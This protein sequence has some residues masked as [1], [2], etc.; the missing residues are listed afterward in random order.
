M[1][2]EIYIL[3]PSKLKKLAD[4]GYELDDET[5]PGFALRTYDPKNVIFVDIMG[6]C[7]GIPGMVCWNEKERNDEIREYIESE[8]KEGIFYKKV[9]GI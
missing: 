7:T 5:M 9:K 3:E 6:S 4:H 2:K 8:I 1:F